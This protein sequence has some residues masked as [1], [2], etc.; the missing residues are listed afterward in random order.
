M[1]RLFTPSIEGHNEFLIQHIETGKFYYGIRRDMDEAIFVDGDYPDEFS[2]Y[3]Y[4]EQ[5][6]R[7][8]H[9]QDNF[10]YLIGKLQVIN[11]NSSPD[12]EYYREVQKLWFSI[13]LPWR[14][15]WYYYRGLFNYKVKSGKAHLA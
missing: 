12:E 8:W 7:L 1:D 2:S 4:F 5:L 9:V 14:F 3:D 15:H 13:T 6:E 11:N 10:D